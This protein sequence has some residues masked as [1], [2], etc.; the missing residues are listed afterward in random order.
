[1]YK[2]NDSL[3]QFI[4]K[5]KSNYLIVLKPTGEW[6]SIPFYFRK[7]I[8]VKRNKKEL[9]KSFIQ[10]F[11][12]LEK[13]PIRFGS[14]Q[15]IE[16]SNWICAAQ[17]VLIA[18]QPFA[19]EFQPLIYQLRYR[20]IALLYRLEGENGGLDRGATDLLMLERLYTDAEK[21]KKEQKIF[22][23]NRLYP[24]EA[25]KLEETCRYPHFVQLL[26]CDSKLRGDF[27][28]WTLRDGLGIEPFVQFPLMQSIITKSHLNGRIGRLGAQHLQV[29]KRQ[30]EKLL[31]LSM[32]GHRE[33]ILDGGKEIVFQGNYRLTINQILEIF[34]DKNLRPGNLEFFAEGV[35]NWNT[36]YLGWWNADKELFEV[37][38]LD[39]KDWWEQLPLFE[40]LTME[41][42]KNRYGRHMNGTFW[43]LSAKASREYLT[44]NFDKSH[45]YLEMA[46]P[47]EEGF[48][49][50]YHFGKFATRFPSNA[51]ELM[52]TITVSTPATIAYPD[53]NVYF[54]ERQHIGFSFCL[55]PEQ[56]RKYMESIKDDILSGREGNIV[57]QIESENCGKWI[58]A[59]LEEQLGKENVPNLYHF[60]LIHAEP[61]GLLKYGWGFI[62]LLPEFWQSRLLALC[63]FPLGAWKGC[64]VID[65]K[66]SRK[67]WKS[68]THSS[69]WE[70]GHVYLPAFL[71]EQLTSGA[72]PTH[73]EHHTAYFS[74]VK[75]VKHP[76]NKDDPFI[77][78]DLFNEKAS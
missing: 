73:P 17:E 74:G 39:K 52:S 3:C 53:E 24:Y 51:W 19:K 33:S 49:A 38:D 35:V 58:Q 13:N 27:F 22:W 28:A 70:T 30:G 10:C 5:L 75:E 2:L 11:D 8:P 69:Y 48:Y 23:E 71:H 37:I 47:T 9:L 6:Y 42:A 43:N 78:L 76:G 68:L 60:P 56:G 15:I 50:I 1:M 54:T 36:H 65:K 32:A 25:H 41:D 67:I 18:V 34:K 21:W 57:F 66:N 44:L 45:A 55:S 29:E 7:L 63:H 61:E 14:P 16:F 31:T 40:L 77:S 26:F 59:K 72:L 62:R 12:S 4:N 20:L 64:W 46:I